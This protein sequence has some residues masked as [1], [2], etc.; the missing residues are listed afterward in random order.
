MTTAAPPMTSGT[1]ARDE[2]TED[3]QQRDGRQRQR[4]ELGPVEVALGDRL[5]V[6]VRVKRPFSKIQY[7]VHKYGI[8]MLGNN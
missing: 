3:Q 6:T 4:D 1:P 2:R 5:D 7:L 8:L